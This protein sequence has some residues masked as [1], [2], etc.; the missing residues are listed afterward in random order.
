MPSRNKKPARSPLRTR[1][2]ANL[3]T[4]RR[5]R[6]LTQEKLAEK[7]DRSVRYTQSIEAGEYWPS[8]PHAVA[9]QEGVEMFVG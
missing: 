6:G 5:K 2:G 1:F 3:G 7:I 4:L 9:A 8:L